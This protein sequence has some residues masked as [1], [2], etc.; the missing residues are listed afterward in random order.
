MALRPALSSGLPLSIA[1]DVWRSRMDASEYQVRYAA[2][3]AGLFLFK[4]LDSSRRKKLSW[5]ATFSCAALSRYYGGR[6]GE[7]AARPVL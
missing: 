2:F 1:K 7:A 5:G 3:K 4:M 6:G